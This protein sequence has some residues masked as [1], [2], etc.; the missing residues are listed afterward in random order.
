MEAFLFYPCG[1]YW[2]R[3]RRGFCIKF[4][5]TIPAYIFDDLAFHFLAGLDSDGVDVLAAL[6]NCNGA[7]FAAFMGYK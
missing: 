7:A 3:D 5:E 2:R 6:V 4:S 1:A